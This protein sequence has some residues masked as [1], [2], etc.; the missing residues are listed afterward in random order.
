MI[1]NP[2]IGNKEAK[3]P[4]LMLRFFNVKNQSFFSLFMNGVQKNDSFYKKFIVPLR[5]V[6]KF[7]HRCD[8]LRALLDFFSK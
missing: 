4:Y 7:S 2:K 5:G 8:N 6:C 3:N 1:K